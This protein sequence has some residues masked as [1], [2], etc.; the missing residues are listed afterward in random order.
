MKIRSKYFQATLLKGEASIRL[1]YF[2]KFILCSHSFRSVKIKLGFHF[3]LPIFLLN[4]L[5][6]LYN[7]STWHNGFYIL[8][9][10]KQESISNTMMSVL[11]TRVSK[12]KQLSSPANNDFTK[13]KRNSKIVCRYMLLE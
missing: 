4:R 8:T 5:V 10:H 13:H 1:R 9:A 7:G 12:S 2:F 11:E 6:S 3:S